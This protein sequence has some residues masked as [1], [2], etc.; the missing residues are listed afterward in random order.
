MARTRDHKAD[1]ARRLERARER[2][3]TRQEGRGHRPGEA[4]RRA[5]REREEFGITGNEARSIRGWTER[6]GNAALDSE[7]V[8]ERAQ[9]KGY[10][11]FQNFRDVLND[12]RRSYRGQ[13]KRGK[14]QTRGMGALEELAEMADVDDISWVYYH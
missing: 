11:W 5:E 8:V 6:L 2:G 13:S 12:A 9:E 3:L 14:Y 4:S 10:A 1:Y 7:D